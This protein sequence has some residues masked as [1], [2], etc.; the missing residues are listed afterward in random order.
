MEVSGHK[1]VL[2]SH[3]SG[4]GAPAYDTAAAAC[5]VTGDRAEE[6][7]VDYLAAFVGNAGDTTARAV[8][9]KCGDDV[10]LAYTVD[11]LGSVYDVGYYTGC[12]LATRD[13]STLGDEVLNHTVLNKAEEAG[14]VFVCLEIY[15][16]R[17]ALAVKP[18]LIIVA[19]DTDY[20]ALRSVGAEVDV[21][22]E[23]YVEF[24]ARSL[25]DAH[26][27]PVELIRSA[28]LI[29]TVVEGH[30]VGFRRTAYVADTVDKVV[31]RNSRYGVSVG[32]C[33]VGHYRAVAAQFTGGVYLGV[34]YRVGHGECVHIL[35]LGVD[36]L[37]PFHAVRLIAVEHV[38]EGA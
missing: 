21:L 4:I 38:C 9:G 11:N 36:V 2:D 6:A 24:L 23:A 18:S 34:V 27:Y 13:D 26:S 3:A 25:V 17:V 32:V 28:Y 1:A 31:V 5:I 30:I 15:V 35:A 29:D 12:V 37:A 16:H 10:H 33:Q 8:A 22:Q 20:S 14:V 7:A 19:A